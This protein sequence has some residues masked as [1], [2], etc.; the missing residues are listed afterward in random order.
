MRIFPNLTKILHPCVV[1]PGANNYLTKERGEL[2]IPWSTQSSSHYRSEKSRCDRATQHGSCLLFPTHFLLDPKE[3]C[4]R[5]PYSKTDIVGVLPTIP[6][7][8]FFPACTFTRPPR[9]L[10]DENHSPAGG[11]GVRQT[12]VCTRYVS[13]ICHPEEPPP[14]HRKNVEVLKI[15]WAVRGCC[16]SFH[17]THSI[18]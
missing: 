13:A 12:T 17:L 6:R 8:F 18:S 3:G 2:T 1:A 7:F 10:V 9:K 5:P 4:K 11:G 14:P 16:V 15:T